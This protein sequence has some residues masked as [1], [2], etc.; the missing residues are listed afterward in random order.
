MESYLYTIVEKDKLREV[1]VAFRTCMKLPIQVLNEKGETI[2]SEGKRSTFCNYIAPFLPPSETCRLIHADAGKKAMELG[3][4]YIFSCHCNLSHIV[5]PLINRETLFG[6]VL[7]GPFLMTEPDS[8]LIMDLAR[9]YPT[10]PTSIL[11][12]LYEEANR[13]PMIPPATVTQI[14]RLLYYLFSNFVSDAQQELIIN[15]QKIHQ[16][17]KIN[18]S[19]QMYKNMGLENKNTYPYEKEKLLL[20]K[21]KSGDKQ[22]ARAVLNDLLG[23]VFFSQGSNLETLKSRI[24]ELCSLLSRSAMD[25]G[26]GTNQILK[27][28]NDFLKNISSI[29]NLDSL[30]YLLQELL[31]TYIECMFTQIPNKHSDTVRKAMEYISKHFSEPITLEEV[32]QHVHLNPSYFSSSFKNA[33]GSSFKEYLN[34]VRV[35]ESKRLLTNTDF[36]LISIAVSTGF[37]DQS[38]FS[39]VFKKYTGITPKQYRR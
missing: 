28:N 15:S 29:N 20:A 37:E 12:D 21:V 38:Y 18:E 6:S 19:I 25:G 10:V 24:I 11:L 33:Y 3:E 27:I 35:E 17:S 1:L 36:P 26:A 5:F 9:R 7:V 22:S 4:T 2:L 13:I 39:K 23:Y 16:Q 32:A 31:D 34:M 30:C 8:E 14:S